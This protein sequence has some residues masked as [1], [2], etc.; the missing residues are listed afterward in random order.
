MNV[1]KMGM[2]AVAGLS[3]V[4]TSLAFTPTADAQRWH[5]H[6]NHGVGNWVGP[7]IVGGLALGALAATAPR[8]YARDCWME[9][10]VL[11]DRRGREVVRRVRV[12]D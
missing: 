4:T 2:A 1:R 10:Q 3:I 12:C 8:A 5:R 11:I 9:R 7:A 6:H